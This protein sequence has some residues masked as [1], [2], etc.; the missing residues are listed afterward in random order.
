MIGLVLAIV[1]GVALLTILFGKM[2]QWL[3]EGL[4]AKTFTE[5]EA[6]IA[7]ISAML[8]GSIGY[9]ILDWSVNPLMMAEK[10]GLLLGLLGL[11]W[12]LFR[13]RQAIG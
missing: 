13:R 7:S 6:A 11:W 12:V 9:L 2:I 1:A 8:G 3:L 5:R 10:V 4:F